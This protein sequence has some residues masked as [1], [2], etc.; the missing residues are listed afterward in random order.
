MNQP[1]ED[2]GE[3]KM[4]STR[5]LAAVMCVWVCVCVGGGAGNHTA[6]SVS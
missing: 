5:R 1:V 2:N 3:N 4:E 6:L